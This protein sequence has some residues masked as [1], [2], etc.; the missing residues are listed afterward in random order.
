MKTI[1][2]L[3]FTAL[4]VLVLAEYMPGVQVQGWKSSLIVALVLAILRIFVRPI[5]VLLTLPIT[6]F[7][8][9]LFLLVINAAIILLVD[10]LISGFHV[11]GFWW[12]FLFSILLSVLQSLFY[13][14]IEEK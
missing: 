14:F 6:I 12:A 2:K 13:A 11:D 9:G 1:L 10:S 5:M 7:S 4:I 3:L 8:L